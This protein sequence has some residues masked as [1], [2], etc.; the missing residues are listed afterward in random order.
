MT[1]MFQRKKR[2]VQDAKR[3]L[4]F[5]PVEERRRVRLNL[6]RRL[7]RRDW[8][9]SP[10]SNNKSER[11]S[12]TATTSTRATGRKSAKHVW[13]LRRKRARSTMR[14]E[15]QRNWTQLTPFTARRGRRIKP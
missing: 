6:T 7:P 11:V 14:G 9:S 13:K 15:R 3:K 4:S 10:R 1:E 12:P 8:A 2:Q 5:R